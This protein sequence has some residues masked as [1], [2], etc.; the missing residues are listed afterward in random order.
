V[1]DIILHAGP[2]GPVAKT[3]LEDLKE[4]ITREETTVWVDVVDPTPEEIA[5]IGEKF[6]FHPLALE[7]VQ[8][9][10]QRPKIDQYDG[11]QYIVFY[12]LTT[13]TDRCKSHEVDI[14]LGKHYMVT[15]HDSLLPVMG[16]TATRWRT[17]VAELDNHGP[18]FLLYSLLDSLVDGYFP[19]LDDIAERADSLEELILLQGQ[20]GLQAE[21]LQLRRDLLMVRRVAGPERDIMNVLVRRDP[22]L[23]G[24]EEIAYFQDVY[25]HLLRVTDSVDIY[26][27]MLSSVLDA[28]LSMISY[29]LN[30][31]V[32]RLTA[33][34]II[35]MSISLVAGVYGMNF[36]HMPELDWRLGYPFALALMA[37]VAV[38]EIA[39]FRRID[40]L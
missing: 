34:S 2:E 4:I 37:T 40:W 30:I 18:G 38:V 13:E 25:D 3:R 12:G 29:S 6:G 19:V 31:V 10:G 24:R 14:F 5:H 11:Y 28:N 33:S 22:P 39:L 32:K 15:F 23:F 17:N 1:I 9:G 16:E 21:I 8:R 7:D 20:P 36:V 26:R 27:D 35:L